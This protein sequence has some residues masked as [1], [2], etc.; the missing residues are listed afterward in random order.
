MSSIIDEIARFE[1]DHEDLPLVPFVQ[2]FLAPGH[3]AQADNAMQ[4]PSPPYPSWLWPQVAEQHVPLER[5]KS[6]GSNKDHPSRSSSG[7]PF[8]HPLAARRH[9]SLRLIFPSGSL[10]APAT[11]STSPNSLS[12]V[13]TLSAS[14]SS[15][16]VDEGPHSLIGAATSLLTSGM[17]TLT[18]V[19]SSTSDLTRTQRNVGFSRHG[20]TASSDSRSPQNITRETTR[21]SS[22][23]AP[24]TDSSAVD[25]E[26]I[27]DG[28]DYDDDEDEDDGDVDDEDEEE[29]DEA[30]SVPTSQYISALDLAGFG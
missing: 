13:N 1:P 4:L 6:A 21:T 19:M 3:S 24:S 18:Q 14:P 11:Y 29:E 2:S 15:H 27:E 20:T 23:A 16:A 5:I 22:I 17:S 9:P 25:E 28:D 30:A 7:L 8:A 10:A 12:R 26:E